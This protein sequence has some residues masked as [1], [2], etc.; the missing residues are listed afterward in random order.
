MQFDETFPEQLKKLQSDE[1]VS[2]KEEIILELARLLE[3][4]VDIN[5][6]KEVGI[7]FS[8]GVDSTLIAYLCQKLGKKFTLYSVGFEDS[9]DMQAAKNTAMKMNWPLKTKIIKLEDCE[10]IFK[11][12]MRITGKTDPISIGVGAVTYSV[13][14]MMEEDRLLTGLGS[15]ELFAGYERHKGNINEECWKGLLD[16]YERDLKRDLSLAKD[17][18]K[19]IKF[20]F[21]DKKLIDYAMKI[22]G[23]LK[24]GEFRKQI[25]RETA[26]QLG[27]AKE[28]AFRKK[29]AAQYG[30]KF[31][32][33]L[34]KLSKKTGL[35]KSAYLKKGL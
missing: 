1:I 17:V 26:I 27:L 32:F 35:K 25:L 34:E 31:D 10:E 23:N 6:D 7:A 18:G 29:C 5:T 13:L 12:V 2:N 24:V 16:I 21:L 33:A 8:G 4:A 20:P 11:E 9:K 22:D 15:E 30:S 28:F 3:N 19:E 14:Q